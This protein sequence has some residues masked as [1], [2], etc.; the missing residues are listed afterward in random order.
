MVLNTASDYWKDLLIFF[1]MKCISKASKKEPVFKKG[2]LV[3]LFSETDLTTTRH[4]WGYMFM[5]LCI[6]GGFR[7]KKAKDGCTMWCNFEIPM[8]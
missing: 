1:W 7:Q 2:A 6:N 8:E 4:I 5:I 3:V